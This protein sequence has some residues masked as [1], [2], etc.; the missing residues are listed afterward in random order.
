MTTETIE[1]TLEV[2]TPPANEPDT[3]AEIDQ[4]KAQLATQA[5]DLDF[6]ANAVLANIPDGLKALIPDALSLAEK[7]KWFNKA[8]AAGFLIKPQ[9]PETDTKKPSL[10]TPKIDPSELPPIARMSYGYGKQ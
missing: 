4:L 1:P 7:V 5:A 10:L 9:V 3:L 6:V 8:Q 2:I